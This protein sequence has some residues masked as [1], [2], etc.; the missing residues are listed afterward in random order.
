MIDIENELFTRIA[1]KLRYEYQP[2]MVV[3]EYVRQPSRF[4]FVS[5]VEQDNST[6]GRSSDCTERHSSL[7]YEINVYS[8]L[9]TGKK[10]ECKK[11]MKT[12]DEEMLNMGFQRIT[13]R[14]VPNL[15]DA[16]VYRIMNRYRG[17]VDDRKYI[18]RR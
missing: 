10:S 18:F 16:T 9:V 5:I 14:P 8:N 2:I 13:S 6:Y 7:M 3:G 4:P 15:E 11:I 17:I 12:I 1:T